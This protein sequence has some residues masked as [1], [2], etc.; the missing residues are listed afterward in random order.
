MTHYCCGHSYFWSSSWH[1]RHWLFHGTF[2]FFKDPF[3]ASDT[4]QDSTKIHQEIFAIVNYKRLLTALTPPHFKP[5]AVLAVVCAENTVRVAVLSYYNKLPIFIGNPKYIFPLV[6]VLC[7]AVS[8]AKKKSGIGIDILSNHYDNE[9]KTFRHVK[10]CEVAILS[11]KKY[12][13]VRLINRSDRKR[14]HIV[15]L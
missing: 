7:F 3:F 11:K 14:P 5:S 12:R 2:T 4:A 6:V 13:L 1:E 8:F 15:H 9:T 10:P